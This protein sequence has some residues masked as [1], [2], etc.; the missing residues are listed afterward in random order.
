MI[1]PAHDHASY[2]PDAIDSALGQTLRPLE[3]IVIDDGS[4]DATP[5]V[6]AAYGSRVRAFRQPNRGVAAARNAGLAVARGDSVA[7][8]DADDEWK[9]RKLERQI[10]RLARDPALGL[11]HCAAERFDASG[12]IE[13]GRL[14]GMEGWVRREILRL[15]REVIAAPGSS[16]LVPR[17]I[18]LDL[19]GF[20]ERL[21]PSEDW[22]FCCRVAAQHPIGYV[23]EVLVRYRQHGRGIHLNIP[24]MERAML[25]ALE[26]QFASSD[27]DVQSLRRHSYGRLHRILAGC[28]FEQRQ[29]R[30]FVRHVM[31][32]LQYDAGNVGYFVAYPWRII[33]RTRARPARSQ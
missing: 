8:L 4:T 11:V 6:L 7:F 12:T 20:D 33:R 16:L 24:R 5:E 30:A 2:L 9:P 3:V 14:T 13:P 15:D 17:R 19:G 25:L 27:A 10:A 26:K 1:I 21:P 23:P 32:S 22:D 28:Y 29:P 31:K 18:A